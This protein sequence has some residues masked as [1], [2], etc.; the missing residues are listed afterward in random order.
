MKKVL[1]VVLLLTSSVWAQTEKTSEVDGFD[2]GGA[3]FG[4][5][6]V[7]S[8]NQVPAGQFGQGFPF[9]LPPSSDFDISYG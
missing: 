8:G 2:F 4:V 6:A 1:I 5:P 7:T 3:E 9:P